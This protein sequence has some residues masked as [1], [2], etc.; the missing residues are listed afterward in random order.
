[1]LFDGI[2]ILML[3]GACSFPDFFMFEDDD[4]GPDELDKAFNRLD[5]LYEFAESTIDWKNDPDKK[6]DA[7]LENISLMIEEVADPQHDIRVSQQIGG[8]YVLEIKYKGINFIYIGKKS[9]ID[10]LLGQSDPIE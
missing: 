10:S 8:S 7:S 2:F 6:F 9:E 3:N 1:L 5:D 4:S